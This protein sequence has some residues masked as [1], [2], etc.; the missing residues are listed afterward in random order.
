LYYNKID[1]NEIINLA[2]D[3]EYAA[4]KARLKNKLEHMTQNAK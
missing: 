3:S 1:P 4:V 2:D